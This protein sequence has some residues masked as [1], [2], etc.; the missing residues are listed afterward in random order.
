MKRY[1]LFAILFLAGLVHAQVDAVGVV[2]DAQTDMPI[3]KV[4]FFDPDSQFLGATDD[5]GRFQV[6]VP[7]PVELTLRKSGYRGATLAL[8]Q[9]GDPLDISVTLDP[10]GARLEDRT[11][12]GTSNGRR[13]NVPGTIAGI[14]EMAG[15]RFDLQEHLRTLPGVSGVREYTSEVSVYGSRSADVVHLL[16]PFAIPNLRHL[17]ISFPG[18]TSVLSPRVLQ[19]IRIEH[20]PSKGP[21]EQGLASAIQYQPLVPPS[22]R[23]DATLSMGLTNRELDIATP[24]AGDATLV[25]SGRWLDPSLLKNLGDRFFAGVLADGKNSSSRDTGKTQTTD[26]DL[27]SFDG[28][29]R[30]NVPIGAMQNSAT[31]MGA[32]DDYR[33]DEFVG[34]KQHNNESPVTIVKGD[35]QHL[36]AFG[37]TEGD[38]PFGYLQAYAGRVYTASESMYGDTIGYLR[39]QHASQTAGSPC[40]QVSSCASD[41]AYWAAVKATRTDD[42]FGMTWRPAA[43]L[44]DAEPEILGVFHLVDDNR[45]HGFEKDASGNIKGG[46][47]LAVQLAKDDFSYQSARAAARLRWPLAGGTLGASAG[48]LWVSDVDAAP[49]ASLSWSG[50]VAGFGVDANTSLRQEEHTEAIKYNTCNASDQGTV[51]C[52]VLGNKRTRSFETKFG[53]GHPLP[54]GII[55]SSTAYWRNY[56][57]PVLPL[58]DMWWNFQQADD[59]VTAN[60]WGGTAE[61]DWRTFHTLQMQI[62]ASRVYGEYQ[63]SG[64]RTLPWE[65]NRDLDVQTLFRIH[66]RSDTLLSIILTHTFSI[67][68]P[69]YQYQLDSAS[70]KVTVQQDSMALAIPSLQDMFRT[71][72]RIQLDLT[73]SIPPFKAFRF[74]F[75][76]QNL[77]ADFDSDW[78][79]YLGAGNARQRGWQPVHGAIDETGNSVP[80]Y[81]KLTPLFSDGTGLYFSFGIE[82]S[83][84]L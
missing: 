74:Y 64:G 76:V 82:G 27:T 32:S 17:D 43:K 83:L 35:A 81:S 28:F 42:R 30:V 4:R 13:S 7:R 3:P 22:D 2:I 78:A 69:Y 37:Q 60:V 50:P 10:L 39:G 8:S 20:D 19:S 1:A 40:Y 36:V 11:V 84:S 54:G 21:L 79:R 44:W 73:S 34:D 65:A 14:E 15:M 24:L 75:E 46:S 57:N 59:N 38:L 71:D 68:K 12:A 45:Q 77:F 49:E 72:M 9:V 56:D 29:A 70:K 31:V 48:G 33:F 25:A 52:D 80:V 41:S 6:R 18:N 5:Q 67:G 66:P 61:L 55:L 26:F 47:S 63:L 53:V 51:I 16:G 23:F 58:P 62:N